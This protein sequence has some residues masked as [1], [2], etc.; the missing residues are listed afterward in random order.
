MAKLTLLGF[1]SFADKTE[2]TF[3]RAITGVVGPNGCGKSNVV[4]AIKWVLGER[5]SKALRGTEMLDVIFAGSAG[6]KPMGMA[7]VVLT[8]ENPVEAGVAVSAVTA[9]EEAEAGANGGGEEVAP[10]TAAAVPE[11]IADSRLPDAEPSEDVGINMAVRGKRGLPIDTDTVE[12]ERRLYRDGTSEYLINSRKARL[13]DI[14]DLF[15]DT[16]IGADAYSIIEQG[17]VDAMLL[18]SPMERRVVFEEAAGV[19]KYRQRRL[20]AERKLDRTE[21][22]LTLAREQLESTERRLRIVKGQA[23]KAKQFKA[24]DGELRAVKMTLACEQFDE[25]HQRLMGLTSRL[26]ELDGERHAA[27][28]QLTAIETAKQEAELTRHEAADELRRVESQLQNARH[29]EQAAQQRSRSAQQSAESVKR[30][31]ENDAAQL[32]QLTQRVEQLAVAQ[33]DAAEQIA[34]LSEALQSAERGLEQA[35]A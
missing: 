10:E 34:G 3:D 26:A 29:E 24:L 13:K 28:A 4:D 32:E 33:R 6:R 23:A 8:F 22:N 11:P 7:S 14:R 17:K 21:T 1:K 12:V 20:E 30:A 27:A 9:A 35:G 15:L 18:A 31:M 19:A 16:G 25:L 5:S 2:F